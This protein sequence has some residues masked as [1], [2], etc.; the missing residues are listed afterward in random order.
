VFDFLDLFFRII[1]MTWTDYFVSIKY[2]V[3]LYSFYGAGE[4]K[5]EPRD[6]RE[7]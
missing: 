1:G 7:M 3:F 4:Q 5:L 2:L 6:Q